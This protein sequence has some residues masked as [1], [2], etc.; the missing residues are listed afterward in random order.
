KKKKKKKKKFLWKHFDINTETSLE[1]LQSIMYVINEKF[2]QKVAVWD[3]LIRVDKKGLD[4]KKL[5]TLFERIFEIKLLYR[6][7]KKENQKPSTMKRRWSMDEIENY[8][9]FLV[10]SYHETENDDVRQMMTSIM[11]LGL[12]ENILPCQLNRIFQMVPDLEKRWNKYQLHRNA[13]PSYRR[14]LVPCLLQEFFRVLDG[15]DDEVALLNSTTTTTTMV[16]MTSKRKI[17]SRNKRQKY[18]CRFMELMIDTLTMLLTRRHLRPFLTRYHFIMRC[19]M[20]QFAIWSKEQTLAKDRL[21][22]QL[23]EQ[24]E[25]YMSFPIDDF[26]GRS[27]TEHDVS[28]DHYANLLALQKCVYKFYYPKLKPLTMTS[29]GSLDNRK[30]LIQFFEKLEPDELR[31]LMIKLNI[32]FPDDNDNVCFQSLFRK[33]TPKSVYL[34]FLFAHFI[35]KES[36]RT[37]ANNL[38]LYPTEKILWDRNIVPMNDDNDDDIDTDNNAVLS[39]PKLNLQFLT[40]YDYLLRNF[41]LFRL[42]SAHSI[43][44]DIAKCVWKIRPRLKRDPNSGSNIRKTH[45]TGYSR[46]GIPVKEFAIT[47]V[48]KPKLGETKPAKVSAEIEVDLGPFVGD[49][50]LEWEALKEHD[51]LFL[52]RVQATRDVELEDDF[53][54]SIQKWGVGHKTWESFTDKELGIEAVRG[55]EIVAVKDEHGTIIGERDWETN[56]VNVGQGSKRIFHVLLDSA[57]YQQDMMEMASSSSASTSTVDI[58]QSFNLL[59]RRESKEN[60]FKAVLETIRSLMN[61]N[62]MALPKWFSNVFLGY[63][64]PNSASF[65]HI[66]QEDYNNGKGKQC[67]GMDFKDTFLDMKHL[68][69]SFPGKHIYIVDGQ[70]NIKEELTPQTEHNYPPPYRLWFDPNDSRPEEE[71]LLK[72]SFEYISP[73][74]SQR[75]LVEPYV[76]VDSQKQNQTN[77]KKNTIRFTPVQIET[78]KSGMHDGLTMVVG[79]PGT[80]KTDVAVQII[81]NIYH[82]YPQQRT[83]LITHSNQA[84]NDL[85]EKIMKQ[86]IDERHLLRLGYGAKELDTESNYSQIG[87]V[88][89]MLQVRLNQLKEAQDLALSIGERIDRCVTCETSGHFYNLDILSKWEEFEYRLEEIEEIYSDKLNHPDSKLNYLSSLFPDGI[90][91]CDLIYNLFPF[92]DFIQ[93]KNGEAPFYRQSYSEDKVMAYKYWKV[94]QSLF[95]DLREC[96]PFELLRTHKDRSQYLLTRQS[97]I[98]AMTCTHAAIKRNDFLQIKFQ[99]DNIVMEESAQILDIETF[100]PMVLQQCDRET[101]C[102]LKRII[103]IGDHQQ[104]PPIVKNAAFQNYS[105]LDQSLFAR[106]VRLGVSTYT[107]NMQGRCRPSIASLFSWKYPH[108]GHLT[109]V[110]TDSIYLRANSGFLFDYQIIHVDD[111]HGRGETQPTP[112]F[113]QNLGEAEY[114][115][116]VYMYMRLLGYPSHQISVLTTYNGQKHLLRDV[117]NR[118]CRDDP[119][120]GLPHSIT[121]VDQYQ[122]QQNHFVLLSLVRTKNVGHIRDIRRLVV[123]LS[124]AKF[125]LYIFARI[126]IFLQCFELKNVFDLLMK[127]PQRLHL[128]TNEPYPTQRQLT[129]VVT[130]ADEQ[131]GSGNFVQSFSVLNLNHMCQIVNFMS[132]SVRMRYKQEYDAQLQ[133][134]HSR[135]QQALEEKR[136]RDAEEAENLRIQ[137]EKEKEEKEKEEK[138]REEKKKEEKQKQKQANIDNMDNNTSSDESDQDNT[139]TKDQDINSQPSM[140]SEATAF[141][142]QT[143]GT[144]GEQEFPTV[145][146]ENFD[147]YMAENEDYSSEESINEKLI[148]KNILQS[149]FVEHLTEIFFVI[150]YNNKA[151]R[152]IFFIDEQHLFLLKKSIFVQSF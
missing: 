125:G 25:F 138:E 131:T 36:L 26:T 2:R 53:E 150:I 145:Q 75:I 102:R 83:L 64:N 56:Q 88:N 137:Q 66:K 12:W 120:F 27:L 87:R 18:L 132:N 99:Y 13:F 69:H 41:E 122:G 42:E 126:N 124:R 112:Y 115:A 32:L 73:I 19:K 8:I 61:D 74:D 123:A 133:Y 103:L 107:L 100:I 152:K 1:H 60:N 5:E 38:P 50:R 6:D 59:M 130:P 113:Y 84:L 127:R 76:I 35:S 54:H 105:K 140:P 98:V 16:E 21:F 11:S 78:I 28:I 106:F 17:K 65:Y 117:F 33:Y 136:K 82:N 14:Q 15:I 24:L 51:I 139:A 91:V 71:L 111:Y 86:D 97:K 23:L 80:G 121:T 135:A 37:K 40:L 62:E 7:E 70:L 95:Q 48:S 67:Y 144:I 9:L 90:N 46:M 79:P 44:E 92:R 114:I 149:N 85:F 34:E 143:L 77:V 81:N 141:A 142:A 148:K 96:H 55:C 47:S 108:L 129:D 101:G 110:T 3:G 43:R 118:R 109:N 134:Y 10:N 22:S 94:V 119:L 146:Q 29:I 52:I 57:Q 49:T 31:D 39:L 68:I 4:K 89:Y 151:H 93:L 104:L 58:Y 45:F 63:G 128:V 72:G 116:H 147:P 30:K 20:S